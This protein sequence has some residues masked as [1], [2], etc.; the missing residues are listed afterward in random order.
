MLT[1]QF[2]KN[3]YTNDETFSPKIIR[4]AISTNQINQIY[5]LHT[6]Q[7]ITMTKVKWTTLRQQDTNP[8]KSCTNTP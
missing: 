6:K 7:Q 3:I 1:Q 4:R 2:A 5:L 8:A